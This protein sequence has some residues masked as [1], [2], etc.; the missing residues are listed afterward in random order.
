MT[1][2]NF[3]LAPFDAAGDPPD[4]SAFKGLYYEPSNLPEFMPYGKPER[5]SDGSVF[6]VS[7]PRVAVQFPGLVLNVLPDE[8]IAAGGNDPR[9]GMAALDLYRM[10]HYA[11]RANNQQIW[12]NLWSPELFIWQKIKC[13]WLWPDYSGKVEGKGIRNLTLTFVALGINNQVYTGGALPLIS[14][15]P[16]RPALLPQLGASDPYGDQYSGGF[17]QGRFGQGPFGKGGY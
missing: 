9:F 6:Y 11:R 2:Q 3:A 5:A 15:D 1:L 12:A 10:W 13:T 17:G 8:A 4:D 7:R 14:F 16:G